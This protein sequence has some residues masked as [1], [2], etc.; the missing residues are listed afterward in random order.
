[1]GTGIFQT[2]PLIV[3]KIQQD[4]VHGWKGEFI[5]LATKHL[6]FGE[7]DATSVK[8]SISTSLDG[9]D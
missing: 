3:T 2:N 4:D 6:G 7:Y 1:M 9:K 5:I 8:D